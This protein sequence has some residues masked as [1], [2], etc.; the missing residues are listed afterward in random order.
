MKVFIDLCAG[1]GGASSA[2]VEHSNWF[3]IQIDNNAEL[4]PLNRHL[5]IG[6]VT[7][8]D[9][10]LTLIEAILQMNGLDI[11]DGDSVECLVVW[12]SPPCDEF[13]LAYNAKG[14]TA[15]RNGEEFNPD[16]SIMLSCK[17]IIEALEPDHW[18]LEN[19]RGALS[20][21]TPHLGEFSQ[22]LGSFFVWGDHPRVDFADHAISKLTK[23]DIRHSPLRAQY[24]AKVHHEISEAIRASI[25]EQTTLDRYFEHNFYTN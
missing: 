2:F 9:A 17:Q 3:V 24:R 16:L 12:A 23:V 13:S 18:Y 19:V 22:K 1:L 20:H 8:V 4:L 6:N 14:P 11:T 15:T 7:D 5:T 25:D 21:F 10:T